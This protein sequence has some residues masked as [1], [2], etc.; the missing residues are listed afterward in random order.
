MRELHGGK[1]GKMLEK[2]RKTIKSAYNIYYNNKNYIE[3]K[4][5]ILWGLGVSYEREPERQSLNF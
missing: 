5:S 3:E 2:L 4:R 1:E